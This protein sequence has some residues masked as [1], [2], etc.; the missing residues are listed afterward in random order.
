M[1]PSQSVGEK[2]GINSALGIAPKTEDFIKQ[3]AMSDMTEIEAAR[4]AQQKGNADEKKIA[5]M[6]IKDHG[7]TSEELKSMVPDEMRAAIPTALDDAHQKSSGGCGAQ[8]QKTLPAN[9]IRCRS[10][11]TKTQCHFSSGTLRAA[12]MLN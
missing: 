9:T 3:V 11:P 12:R 2:T 8:S 10:A 7:K 4:I 1:A 6:M 5:E